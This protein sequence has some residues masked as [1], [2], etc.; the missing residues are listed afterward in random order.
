MHVVRIGG[1]QGAYG[2]S[3]DVFSAYA[4]DPVDY[5]VC[6]S[7]A[8][9]TCGMLAL[10]QARDRLGQKPLY[11]TVLPGGGIA[12]LAGSPLCMHPCAGNN[13]TTT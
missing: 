13:H 3:P 8:E 1:G 9:T 5:L 11:Y 4:R 10:D 12:F 7:L 6:D 2:E